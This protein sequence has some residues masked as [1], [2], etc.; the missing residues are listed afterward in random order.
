MPT[1][2]H[3]FVVSAAPDDVARFHFDPAAF[4]ALTP[5]GILLRIHQQDPLADGSTTEFTLW[6]GPIRISWTAQHSEVSSRGF[7]DTQVRGPMKSWIHRH[8]FKP[9][10]EDRTL[11]EDV[12]EYQHHGG[13]RGV[14]SALLFSPPGLKLLFAWRA[15]A[16][17][18]A[19][20]EMADSRNC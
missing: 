13:W 8:R 18:R 1:F 2:E 14:R 19:V 17:R 3:H 10:P 9:I 7:T 11:V 15:R 5:L 4:R 6:M 20:A 12:I 16:T